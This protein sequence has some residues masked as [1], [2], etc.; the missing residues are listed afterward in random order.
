VPDLVHSH[1]ADAGYGGV[2]LSGLLGVPLVLALSRT[3]RRK[4]ILTLL[5]AHGES[6]DLKKIANLLIIAGNRD[7]IQDLDAGPQ[8][9]LTELLFSIGTYDLYGRVA[10]PK[11][12]Q[13]EEVPQIYRL[14]AASGGVFVNPALTEPFGL[15]LLEAVATGLPLVATENGGPLDVIGNCDNGILVNPLDRTAIAEALSKLLTNAKQYTRIR[16][17]GSVKQKGHHRARPAELR[18]PLGDVFASDARRYPRARP[19]R[20]GTPRVPKIQ[21]ITSFALAISSVTRL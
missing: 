7:D 5:Q 1:Y 21:G 19:P 12:H 11:H 15:T 13:Q 14:A 6:E 18:E 9:V 4:N 20:A 17:N 10:I 2:R 8:S 3:D 16:E